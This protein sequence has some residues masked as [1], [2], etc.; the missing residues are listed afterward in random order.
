M[1]QLASFG[2]MGIWVG[3]FSSIMFVLC[4]YFFLTYFEHLKHD[5]DEQIRNSKFLAVV[6]LALALIVPAFYQLFL[7]N[8]MMN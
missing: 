6:T 5:D 4:L 2:T 1:D 3:I 7:F 8:Q